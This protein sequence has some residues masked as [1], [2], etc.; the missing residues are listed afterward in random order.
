MVHRLGFAVE[1]VF[2]RNGFGVAFCFVN[3]RVRR[4]VIALGIT[5]F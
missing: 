5:F 3:L 4:V 2:Y 1:E